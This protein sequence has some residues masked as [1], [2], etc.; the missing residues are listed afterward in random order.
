MHPAHRERLIDRVRDVLDKIECGE[1]G[2]RD[3]EFIVRLNDKLRRKRCGKAE[4]RILEMIEPY[5]VKY[6]P[7]AGYDTIYPWDD[8]SDGDIR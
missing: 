2:Q 7:T 3:F 8:P 1:A 5:L 6:G 4:R